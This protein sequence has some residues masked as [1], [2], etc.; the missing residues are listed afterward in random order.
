MKIYVYRGG[1]GWGGI[2]GSYLIDTIEKKIVDLHRYLE[3]NFYHPHRRH[4]GKDGID[5][6]ASS[7]SDYP[8]ECVRDFN[9]DLSLFESFLDTCELH[10]EKYAMMDQQIDEVY[11]LT[12]SSEVRQ[13]YD[14]SFGETYPENPVLH[15]KLK[16]F[17]DLVSYNRRGL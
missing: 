10:K 1:S 12:S 3:W 13:V 4:P 6:L 17:I 16:K 11:V 14:T 2:T 8:V 5:C 15:S 9:Y 7:I